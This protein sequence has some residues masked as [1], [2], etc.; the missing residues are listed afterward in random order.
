MICINRQQTDPFFNLA[1]EEYILKNIDDNVFMLW[2]NE[3]SVVIGKHQNTLA[4]VNLEF[5]AKN[6]IPVIRRISGGGTVF[7]DGG[8]INYTLISSEKNRERLIDFRKFTQPIIDFLETLDIK[9]S[10][11]GKNN[12]VVAGKKISGNSAHV[13][14]NRVMH[15]GTLLFNSNLDLLE[16]A[17]HPSIFNIEDKAVQSIRAK[18]GNISEFITKETDTKH[19]KEQLSNFLLNYHNVTKVTDLTEVHKQ[20]IQTLANTKYKTPGWNFGY[21]PAYTIKVAAKVGNQK[22]EISLKVAKGLIEKANIKGET[23]EINRL[24]ILLEKLSGLPHYSDDPDSYL[25]QLSDNKSDLKLLKQLF[26]SP[27]EKSTK[28]F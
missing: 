3:P 7:H 1:A 24:R 4:E 20:E 28:N 11:E 16:K 8:N 5:V 12:L 6:N 15:H 21:S 9:A 13:F 22:T 18:V 17:I 25:R 10:Y 14:K 27:Y 26:F 19:F 2:Q 23:K